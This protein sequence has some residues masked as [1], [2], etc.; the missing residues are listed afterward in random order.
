MFWKDTWL[1]D[2]PLEELVAAVPLKKINNKLSDYTSSTGEWNWSVLEQTL[3]HDILL[4][5]AA[6]KLNED[7]NEK[8]ELVWSKS[9]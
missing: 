3:P 9:S 7:P 2:K 4:Q 6:F 8:D 5:L 1:V